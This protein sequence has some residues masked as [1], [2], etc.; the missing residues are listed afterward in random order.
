LPEVLFIPP[1]FASFCYYDFVAYY[2]LEKQKIE[3]LRENI[4]YFNQGKNLLGL[5]RF[6]R[7]K[8]AIQ[9]A[10]I[11]G[12]EKVKAIATQLQE[13][14]FDVKPFFRQPCQRVRNALFC[15]IVIIPKKFGCDALYSLT[16]LKILI[17]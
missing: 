12:N 5:N 3:V 9:S 11:P 4:I 13:N 8:S 1:V 16:S 6:V 10:I 17:L 2:N 7:S 14:G 15:C